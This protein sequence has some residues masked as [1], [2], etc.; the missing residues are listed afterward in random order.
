MFHSL[1]NWTFDQPI[2]F[3]A[4]YICRWCDD[5][6][7]VGRPIF[8]GLSDVRRGVVSAYRS[9]PARVDWNHRPIKTVHFFKE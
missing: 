6:Q 9:T 8:G 4:C 7:T 5:A 2:F 1:V 3:C